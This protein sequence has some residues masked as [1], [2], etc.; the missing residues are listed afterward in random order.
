M[1][2]ADLLHVY[3]AAGWIG[4]LVCV[5]LLARQREVV[6]RFSALALGAVAVVAGTGVA[7]AWFELRAVE[8]LWSTGYGRTLLVKSGLLLALVGLGALNRLRLARGS[9]LGRGLS[10][11]L[12]LLAGVVAAVSLLTLLRPGRD[13]PIAAARPGPPVAHAQPTPPPR[14]AVVL[15]REAGIYGVAL[16]VRGRELTATVLSPSGGGATGLAVAFDLPTGRFL[17]GRPCGSGC[18]RAIASRRP[19]RVL[20]RIG[21]AP[22]APFAIPARTPDA[23]AL[24]R[25]STRAYRALR[26]VVFRERLASSPTNAIVTLW[27]L[28]APDSLSYAIDNGSRAVVIGARRWD[29]LPGADW[30]ESQQTPLVV[31][32]PAWGGRAVDAHLLERR[33]RVDVVS[34]ANPSIPAWFTVTIDR[35]SGLPRELEMTAAAH[36]MHHDYLRFNAP[37][38]IRPPR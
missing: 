10:G 22:P 16:A 14:G 2:A 34:F 23:S 13:A 32:Q 30:I 15:A 11:E 31:P 35:R 18:Y 29:Q 19:R 12:V 3:A 24:V 8:Q 1:V 26:T 21:G 17:R 7:R 25:R 4:G 27:R 6:R 5:A 38:E 37:V 28:R 36:F 20:V 33:A 9:G